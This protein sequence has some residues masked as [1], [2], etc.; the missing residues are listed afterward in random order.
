MSP[1]VFSFVL[2][3]ILVYT[4]NCMLP[5]VLAASAF[6]RNNMLLLLFVVVTGTASASLLFHCLLSFDFI[7]CLARITISIFSRAVNL[8]LNV[9]VPE[10]SYFG[11]SS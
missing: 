2:C 11:P 5:T 8:F 10:V 4:A 1:P 3:L 7:L 9:A 6:F